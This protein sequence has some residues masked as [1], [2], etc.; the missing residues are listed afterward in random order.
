[1]IMKVYK[2]KKIITIQKTTHKMPLE[3]GL[4][5][6]LKVLERPKGVSEKAFSRQIRRDL[7]TGRKVFKVRE[8][9]IL[10]K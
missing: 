6:C 10:G 4:S 5:L 8:L 1:M 9:A 3:T 2:M 7:V